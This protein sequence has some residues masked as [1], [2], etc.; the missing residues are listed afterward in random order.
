MNYHL[1]LFILRILSH[2]YNGFTPRHTTN[3]N[4]TLER[5]PRSIRTTLSNGTPAYLL[6][7]GVIL[8]LVSCDKEL[9]PG[10]PGGIYV[11][12]P[13][14]I[15]DY[16][17]FKEGS[18]WIYRDSASGVEDSVYVVYS[19]DTTYWLGN[20]IDSAL[21]DI[22]Y[23]Y[24]H[25]DYYNTDYR[26]EYDQYFDQFVHHQSVREINMNGGGWIF[27]F[28]FPNYVGF[29]KYSIGDTAHFDLQFSS[30]SIGINTFY[31][32]CKIT[33]N[34]DK[35]HNNNNSI[36]YFASQVGCIKQQFIEQG[37]NFELVR[38]KTVK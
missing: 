33:H 16:I 3:T 11:E 5:N 36:Y 21:Y 9:P 17:W 19:I 7:A 28:A 23:V 14:D 26:F 30:L 2:L 8:L 31:K 15:R 4:Q 34:F 10:E 29:E 27:A 38:F 13:D 18:Y 6:L 20:G 1:F 24:L 12:R 37:I 25:S 32:V 35:T 22:V